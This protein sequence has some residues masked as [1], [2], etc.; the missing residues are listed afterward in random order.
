MAIRSRSATI[1]NHWGIIKMSNNTTEILNESINATTN[2]TGYWRP[3]EKGS[4]PD[5]ETLV[6][7]LETYFSEMLISWGLNPTHIFFQVGLG[8]SILVAIYYIFVKVTS[9][10]SKIFAPIFYIAIAIIILMV[11]EVV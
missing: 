2:S 6:L 7:N 4:L 1:D 9:G 3:F 10:S 8:A 11:L 5:I